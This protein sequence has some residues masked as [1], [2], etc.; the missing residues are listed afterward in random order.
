MKKILLISNQY[1]NK[2]GVG[3]P[4]MM[5]MQK[6]LA[7]NKRILKVDFLQFRNNILSLLSIRRT[8]KKYDII[9]I[10]F[11]G[12]YSLVLWIFL[13]DLNK[14]M[15]ITFHG[16]DIHAK[17]KKS[18]KSVFRK[19]KISLNQKAS[20]ICLCLF[21]KCGFVSNEMTSYI[22]KL[23]KKFEFKFFQQPLG[24]DYDLFI[25][26]PSHQAQKEL[27]L[28]K[29]HYILFSDV[30]NTPIKR[31]DIATEIVEN[32]GH[33]YKLLIMCGVKPNEVPL[34]INA[35]DFVI[36]TSDEEGS[37]NIIREALAL[38]KPFF[39][40]K[41]GDA[42]YQLKGLTNSTIISR[43]SIKAAKTIVEYLKRPYIDNT[44][45]TLQGKIDFKI[46][47][48][49]LIDLYEGI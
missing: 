3:N 24:V 46:I 6:A 48:E 47:N 49:S 40:V 15:F 44:R 43:D 38:N 42:E 16:T 36:L 12:L 45:V 29:G 23:L 10:H 27:G 22:P 11:G 1:L 26:I 25:P 35:C 9:H 33:P 41:V 13:C 14:R 4:I 21:D 34:Y 19:L 5:R 8:A 17:S 7:S 20:F 31:R 39:S 18:T 32:I 37:P 2:N 30:S 28:P